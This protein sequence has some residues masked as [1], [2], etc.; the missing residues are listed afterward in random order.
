M[1]TACAAALLIGSILLAGL[2]GGVT[3]YLL[4]LGTTSSDGSPSQ[5]SKLSA[6]QHILIGITAA[7]LAPLFLSLS[8]SSLI[9]E[10]VSGS[11][12]IENTLIFFGTSLLAAVSARRFME[13]LTQRALSQI[14]RNKADIADS[15]AR[16]ERLEE[17]ADNNAPQ[18]SP[19]DLASAPHQFDLSAYSPEEQHILA[20]L[21]DGPLKKRT[22]EGLARD[23][24]LDQSLVAALLGKLV[25]DQ[26]V[27]EETGA[28]TGRV[29]YRA[30]P[31][32]LRKRTSN[33]GS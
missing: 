33:S 18:R 3:G 24:H 7:A 23:L 12:L 1:T 28:V 15:K 14:A 31:S 19:R 20:L 5:D 11:K 30:N 4:S 9:A 27:I 26:V 10:I 21:L 13:S 32:A 16:T 29:L 22:C 25:K 8:K 17:A 2:L 6:G